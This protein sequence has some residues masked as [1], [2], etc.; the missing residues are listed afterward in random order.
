MECG[1]KLPDNAKFCFNCGSRVNIQSLV[2]EDV[3]EPDEKKD[4][5]SIVWFFQIDGLEMG[6]NES[7]SENV[8]YKVPY[9]KQECESKKELLQYVF[10]KVNKFDVHTIIKTCNIRIF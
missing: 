6:V 2:K 5:E 10:E 4:G 9:I 3:G 1:N 7:I 8:E